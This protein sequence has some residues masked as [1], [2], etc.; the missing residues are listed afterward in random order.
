MTPTPDF[1]RLLPA[2]SSL[3]SLL[4]TTSS[5]HDLSIARVTRIEVIQNTQFCSDES[6]EEQNHKDYNLASISFIRLTADLMASS[7]G[8]SGGL[9]SW[10]K[11]LNCGLHG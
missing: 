11:Q 3:S 4:W 6:K 2:C 7:M 5:V 9:W 1:A 8:E 10:Q